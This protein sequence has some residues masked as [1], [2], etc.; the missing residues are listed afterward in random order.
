MD[1]ASDKAAADLYRLVQAE[2]YLRL[3][4]AAHGQDARSPEALY[5]WVAR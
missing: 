1:H 5:E 2:A 4:R 3:Y